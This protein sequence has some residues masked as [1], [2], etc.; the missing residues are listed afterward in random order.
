MK[1]LLSVLSLVVF[2]FPLLAQPLGG[3]SKEEVLLT[4][5][6]SARR[7]DSYFDALEKYETAY[8]QF[9][10][11]SIRPSIALMN[12]RLR[13]LASANRVYKQV[14]RKSEISDTTNNVHRYHYGRSLKMAGEYDEAQTY[15]EAFLRH[16]TD[17][18]L[19]KRAKLE[20][21]G[22]R[23]YR[24]APKETS[25][26]ALEGLGRQV[27]GSFSEYS[28][29][30]SSDG[31]TLYFSTIKTTEAV[32][33]G[34]GDQEKSFLQIYTSE[35]SDKGDW[36]R[37]AALGKEVNR[38]GIHTAN[39]A[40]S[41]DGRRLYFNRLRMESNGIAEAKIYM[42]DVD[43]DG[44]KSANPVSGIN[45][46]AYLALQPATGELFGRE[47]LFFVSDMDGGF[48]GM[49]IYYANYEGEGRYGAPVN[50][51]PTIN[52]IGDDKTPFYFD[53]TLYF[54]TDGRPTMG[55]YDLFLSAWNGS[56]WSEP[57][58]MGPGFNTTVDDKS[59]SVFGDGL[60]G[61]MTSNREGGRSVKSKTCCDDI[62]GFQI[63]SLYANLVVG[64]FNEAKEAL[65]TGTIELQPIINGSA[66]GLGEQKSRDDGNRFDFGLTLETQYQVVASH[67]GY[68]PDTVEMN[69]LGLEESKEFQQVFFL[70]KVPEPVEPTA[71]YDTVD[72]AEAITLENILYDFD[73]DKILPA[74]EPDLREVQ[75]WMEQYP[76]MII[77]L[78]SHTD[79]R[80]DAKYNLGLSKRRAASARKWLIINGDIAGPRIKTQG[81]GKT[82]PQIVSPRLAERV[83][84]LQEGDVLTD[85]FI[86]SLPDKPAQERAHDFNRRTEFKILE[87]PT[88]IIIRRDVIERKLEGEDRGA[89]PRSS[90]TPLAPAAA[91]KNATGSAVAGAPTTPIAMADHPSGAG[92]LADTITPFSSLYGQ[93]K[94]AGL[95]VLQFT[96]RSL[97][98]GVVPHGDT[99][100]MDYYFTNTGTVPAKIM[101][102]QACT[103]T[104]YEHDN[105]I[106]YQ[107]GDSGHIKVT[108]DSEEKEEGETITIDIYL[109]QTDS[110]D[111]P[112]LEMVEYKFD[113][114]K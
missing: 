88:S 23:L 55:G 2:A 79:S 83:D 37:S 77:E 57:E 61:F 100:T 71:I 20:L 19:E 66:D 48:G 8:D 72:I 52:T 69:T 21:E 65:T 106:V 41:T 28:P 13:D 4:N 62:Y 17:G 107:P 113:L 112:I 110:R 42:S 35:K 7:I 39:P 111:V 5:A 93:T 81:Y 16:N 97:D 87:G 49:D 82:V 9:E 75:K 68:F 30:L 36:G 78:G 103:C 59:L 74:A 44:W 80:G 96:E 22:I 114:A 98:L 14:F 91:P 108:F 73:D 31:T 70:K 24:D 76:D 53:G 33:E 25:E 89:E 10:E 105:S 63:A 95:P 94:V 92:T 1:Y 29:V 18:T 34:D 15:F 3:T 54:S 67:P 85:A 60:V 51:G 104:S 86:N 6:D 45:G 101:L 84:F 58:N 27:N 12:L 46:D 64:L 26:V 50:L 32:I 102:I 40:L 90:T 38:P 47:V 11:E 43:D 56:E 109:E 99:R